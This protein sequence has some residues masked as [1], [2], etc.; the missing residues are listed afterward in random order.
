[1]NKKRS[2][3]MTNVSLTALEPGWFPFPRRYRHRYHQ[4]RHRHFQETV[5]A[6]S[7]SLCPPTWVTRESRVG[8][9]SACYW[10]F[11]RPNQWTRSASV[12]PAMLVDAI[13]GL[14]PQGPRA[15]LHHQ[16]LTNRQ[17]R[18]QVVRPGPLSTEGS[19][20]VTERKKGIVTIIESHLRSNFESAN[21]REREKL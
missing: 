7:V 15:V 14:R 21:F 2:I 17:T 4:R 3:R 8:R 12:T 5:P 11:L 9:G 20:S 1:M 13:S 10:S 16:L 18:P 6:D 19:R